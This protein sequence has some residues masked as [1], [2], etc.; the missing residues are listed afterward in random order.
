MAIVRVPAIEVK[1]VLYPIHTFK[2]IEEG[3]YSETYNVM[4]LNKDVPSILLTTYLL[5]D[6][7][8][9]DVV[10]IPEIEITIQLQANVGDYVVDDSNY[11]EGLV[12]RKVIEVI[13]QQPN[14]K[15]EL[16]NSTWFA[17]LVSSGQ[18]DKKYLEY[19][20][21]TVISNYCVYRLDNDMLSSYVKRIDN[22]FLEQIK[23][24][25]NGNS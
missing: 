18:V 21:V 23:H 1:K 14:R 13:P 12:V 20:I 15:H 16:T 19:P 22:K 4:V 25:I 17:K 8:L 11:N 24:L 10:P 9:D 3:F 7:E 2:P 6:T 5:Y